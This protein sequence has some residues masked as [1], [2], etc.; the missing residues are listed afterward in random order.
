MLV[1]FGQ[2]VFGQP[3]PGRG[4]PVRE[5]TALL[6]YFTTKAG[7]GHH[8]PHIAGHLVHDLEPAKRHGVASG[9]IYRRHARKGFGET[10]K[11]FSMP[12]TSL[13][14][15]SMAALAETHRATEKG[16][17]R[18]PLS[19]APSLLLARSGRSASAR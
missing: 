7:I 16:W 5:Q 9:W 19:H 12:E 4:P 3:A 15:K 13:L 18:S 6:L 2:P 14:P 17:Q 1:L 8:S 10:M 11:P